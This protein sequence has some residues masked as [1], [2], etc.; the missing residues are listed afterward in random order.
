MNSILDVRELI[1]ERDRRLAVQRV[2]MHRLSDR[3]SDAAFSERLFALMLE[4]R[5]T[6]MLQSEGPRSSRW[7]L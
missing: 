5:E 1:R 3:R 6:I 2:V 4:A 7:P